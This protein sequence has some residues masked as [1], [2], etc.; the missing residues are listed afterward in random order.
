[1]LHIGTNGLTAL[2]TE[3]M[4]NILLKPITGRLKAYTMLF[5]CLL[6]RHDILYRN[7]LHVIFFLVIVAGEISVPLCLDNYMTELSQ[8]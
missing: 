6:E 1:M 5:M 3:S 7:P 8:T 4:D 2:V